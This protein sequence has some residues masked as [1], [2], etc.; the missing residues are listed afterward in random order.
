MPT[1][2][3]F[4]TKPPAFTPAGMHATTMDGAGL[5]IRQDL[6][7]YQV[8]PLDLPGLVATV[9]PDTSGTVLDV[10]CG[11]GVYLQ[12]VLAE[13]PALRPVGLDIAHDMLR[14]A[15]AA[16][17]HRLL[18]SIRGRGWWLTAR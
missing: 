11:N 12:R 3:A 2:T 13:R 1:A 4:A 16:T 10:G 9:L 6:Y 15:R 7:R 5:I 17:G 8:P 14:H 18:A